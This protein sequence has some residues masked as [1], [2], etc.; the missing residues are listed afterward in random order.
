MASVVIRRAATEVAFWIA[1]RTTLAGFRDLSL[2]QK[3][4]VI[5]MRADPEPQQS[6]IG[7]DSERA[8]TQA[9]ADAVIA[10]NLLEVQ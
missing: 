3:R 7:C 6:V 5:G 10:A 2:L 1:A 9:D 8:I 4:I